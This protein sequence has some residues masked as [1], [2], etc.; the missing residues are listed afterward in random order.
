MKITSVLASAIL[1]YTAVASAIPLASETAVVAA[2]TVEKRVAAPEAEAEAKFT[3]HRYDI[4]WSSLPGEKR[5][6]KFTRHPYDNGWGFL[7]GEKRDA[8]AEP[9]FTRHPYDNGWGSLPGEKR[10]AEAEP[11][12]TRHPYDNGVFA[13]R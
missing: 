13:P 1:A 12:F 11:R 3:C 8:E 7:S 2:E 6:A 10:D 5:D 4:G 9:R